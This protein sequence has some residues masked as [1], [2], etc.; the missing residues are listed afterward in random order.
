MFCRISFIQSYRSINN[1]KDQRDF[2]RQKMQKTA[3]SDT[4]ILR[5]F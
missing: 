3:E 2:F 5:L 4:E 1:L